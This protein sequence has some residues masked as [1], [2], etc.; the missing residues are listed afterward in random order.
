MP[1]IHY[2][3]WA[4]NDAEHAAD[5]KKSAA[6]IASG[7]KTPWQVQMENSFIPVDAKI[8]VDL[9]SFLKRRARRDA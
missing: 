8:E 6:A 3:T 2:M 7:E 9:D 4:E 1:E 5:R